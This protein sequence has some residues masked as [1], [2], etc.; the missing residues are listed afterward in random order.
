LQLNAREKRPPELAR[1]L[2]A[3]QPVPSG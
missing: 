1:R 2:A 3:E